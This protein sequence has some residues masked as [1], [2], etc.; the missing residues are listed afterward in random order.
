MFK[1]VGIIGTGTMGSGIATS[2]AQHDIQVR[3][4]DQSQ[5][6]AQGAITTASRFYARNV[7]KGR[8][9][10]QDMDAALARLSAH[11]DLAELA[12]CDLI[13]EAVFESMD[14]KNQLYK[15][16]NPHIAP[17]AVVATNTSCLRVSELAQAVAAPQRFVGLHYFNPAAINP[18]VEVVRGEDSDPDVVETVMAFCR[19]TSKKPLLCKDSHGFAINRFF[20]P[21][22]NEAIRVLED[23]LGSTATIDAIAQKYLGAAGGPFMV[24][25]LVKPRIMLHAQ[26]NL[27]PHGAFYQVASTLSQ[28][29]DTDYTFPIDE[30]PAPAD[31]GPAH[32][33]TIADRLRAAVFFPVLQELEEGVA[34]PSAIDLGAK[35]ALRFEQP[36]CALMDQLGGEEVRRIIT[37]L[38]QRYQHAIPSTLANVGS[39]I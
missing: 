15:A 16:I 9:S 3:L 12:P 22:G 1:V 21:Y 24:M 2:L 10:Q 20:V 8:M 33:Q 7:D 36:P 28:R 23:G 13:I 26:Q 34:E 25:N 30:T 6:L 17:E 29:G 38:C 14:I 39:L 4:F 37:P 27:E 11:D 5:D 19:A 35:L 32:E 31:P 18:I